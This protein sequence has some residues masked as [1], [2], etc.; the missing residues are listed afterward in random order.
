MGGLVSHCKI[1]FLWATV[2]RGKWQNQL[3][4]ENIVPQTALTLGASH[5]SGMA[6]AALT[7]CLFVLGS[8][9]SGI[10]PDSAFKKSLLTS[11]GHHWGCWISTW[12]HLVQSKYPTNPLYYL[13]SPEL[14]SLLTINWKFPLTP[15]RKFH[16]H[17][18]LS[19]RNSVN[20][21][22]RKVLCFWL[23]FHYCK[24][25]QMRS[26]QMERCM[27]KGWTGSQTSSYTTLLCSVEYCQTGKHT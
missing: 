15:D 9:C 17:Y 18:H 5:K 1:E 26:S 6:W 16:Q 20:T 23:S 21:E 10:T 22:V 12:F 13:S 14:S 25:I 8:Q 7:C 2:L 27:G 11:S 3:H 24:S 19:F 4:G